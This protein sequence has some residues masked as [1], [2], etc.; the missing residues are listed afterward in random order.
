MHCLFRAWTEGRDQ[1]GGQSRHHHGGPA[2]QGRFHRSF[3]LWRPYPRCR[4]GVWK[5]VLV[6]H[7]T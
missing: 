6:G 5:H 3:N 2:D 4:G 7:Y 1:R